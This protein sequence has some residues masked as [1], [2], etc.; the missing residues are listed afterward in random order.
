MVEV[1]VDEVL[2]AARLPRVTGKPG[3]VRVI[4]DYTH[5]VV[6]YDRDFVIKFWR[7]EPKQRIDAFSHQLAASVLPVP[8]MVATGQITAPATM[9]L[10]RRF[11]TGVGEPLPFTIYQAVAGACPAEQTVPAQ[12]PVQRMQ[13]YRQAGRWLQQ[14]HAVRQFEQCGPLERFGTRWE[15]S[16]ADWC[17]F[18][19]E[20]ID[21]WDE[22]L[23]RYELPRPER[24]LRREVR[25][26]LVDEL[27]KVAVVDH[28]VL[29]HRDYSLRN[30]L[31]DPAGRLVAVIDFEHAIAGDPV[32]DWHRIATD[33]LCI[34]PDYDCWRSFLAGYGVSEP[35][36]PGVTARLYAY[37]ALYGLSVI[38]Y[39]LRESDAA[40]YRKGM[41][42][43]AW[44][45]E[46]FAA[47]GR[48]LV[49]G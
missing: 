1:L 24:R 11:L 39:A 28:F 9:R 34:N 13:A 6:A 43:I 20:Q 47:V 29:C 23:L 17:D 10:T 7:Y 42:L 44:V 16:S 49:E 31:A 15:G 18:L 8:K 21:R 5:L 19:L 25:N 40:Y 38:G 14:L 30:L 37:L 27:P 4:G 26:R 32:F 45:A 12:A 41:K 36:E 48:G 46:Q 3:K 2:G 22:Q 33:L 35:L